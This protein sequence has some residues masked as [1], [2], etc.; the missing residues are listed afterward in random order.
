MVGPEIPSNKI[1]PL[2]PAFEK[3]L[4][5]ELAT[6]ARICDK[7]AVKGAVNVNC[8]NVEIIDFKTLSS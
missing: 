2:F 7:G 3:E 6:T 8:Q 4:R 5:E 1:V